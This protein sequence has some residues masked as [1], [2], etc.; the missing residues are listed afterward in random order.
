M[1]KIIRHIS[2]A[3]ML[4]LTLACQKQNDGV[5][6]EAVLM[7]SIKDIDNGTKALPSQLVKPDATD[8]TFNVV[9][10]ATSHSI[11]TGKAIGEN[12]SIKVKP[13]VEYT[14]SASYGKNAGAELDAPYYTGTSEAVSVGLNEVKNVQISC[15][16]GNALISAVYGSTSTERQRFQE[17]YSSYGLYVRCEG[18]EVF[19]SGTNNAYIKAGSAYTVELKAISRQ[20][21]SE[22]RFIVPDLPQ[23]LNAKDNLKITFSL[24]Q[25]ADIT[26]EKAEITEAAAELSI[27][28]QW[29][30]MPQISA[31]HILDQDGTLLGTKLETTESYPGCE[32]TAKVYN[33]ANILVRTINGTGAPASDYTDAN[34]WPYLPSGDYYATFSYNNNNSQIEITGKKREFTIGSPEKMEIK[35]S[36]ET[37]YTRYLDNDISGANA[38]NGTGI[39]N[40]RAE[41]KISENIKNNARYSSLLSSASM[42]G[43]IDNNQS[44]AYTQSISS[45]SHTADTG[46]IGNH[47]YN[48]QFTF[49]GGE[50]NHSFDF[51]VSGIPYTFNF[52]TGETCTNEG[53][54]RAGW[55]VN[56]HTGKAPT[57]NEFYTCTGKEKGYVVSPRYNVPSGITVKTEITYKFYVPG[58][59]PSQVMTVYTQAVNSINAEANQNAKSVKASGS[60]SENSGRRNISVDLTLTPDTP[61]ISLSNNGTYGGLFNA[62][63]LYLHEFKI[64]YR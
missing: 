59:N 5:Q 21:N 31:V 40:V 23:Q 25:G 12:K 15:S 56:G 6:G 19:M 18:T 44:G 3:A 42:K 52:K 14:V 30:P 46:I 50:F 27:P 33:S 9:E 22:K 16:L 34:D 63:F 32:W 11:F 36:Y 55:T 26:V 54:T 37:S 8:F 2:L 4:L 38:W 48:C 1:T 35:T 57:T 45:F 61:Y 62:S 51:A 24:G 49:D 58:V 47:S 29:L 43:W 13:N 60:T 7:I 10:T 39:Y 17:L 28:Y 64:S 41:L 20:D 53:V